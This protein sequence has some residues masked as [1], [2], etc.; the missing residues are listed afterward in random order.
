MNLDDD[1]LEI[2]MVALRLLRDR[3]ANAPDGTGDVVRRC[4]DHV[5]AK[6]D[7]LVDRINQ[8]QKDKENG[9]A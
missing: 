7:L 8:H 1:E 4:C 2:V 9:D 3:A 5:A 6:A